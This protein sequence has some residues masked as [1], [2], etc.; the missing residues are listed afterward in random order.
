VDEIDEVLNCE[1]VS[2]VLA[3]S[4]RKKASGRR[5]DDMRRL[6]RVVEQWRHRLRRREHELPRLDAGHERRHAHGHRGR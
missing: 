2:S 1:V 3:K 6:D 4:E 5:H